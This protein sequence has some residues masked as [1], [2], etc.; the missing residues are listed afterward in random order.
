[1]IFVSGAVLISTIGGLIG[2]L[3]E[4]TASLATLPVAVMVVGTAGA[5]IPAAMAMQRIGRRRGFMLAI[6]IAASDAGG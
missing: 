1:M 2:H 6:A 5:T 4:T 3:L